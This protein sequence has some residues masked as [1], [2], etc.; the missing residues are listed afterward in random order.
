MNFVFDTLLNIKI[1]KQQLFNKNEH[2]FLFDSSNK[3]VVNYRTFVC[4]AD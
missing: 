2:L 1:Y 3:I 4:T